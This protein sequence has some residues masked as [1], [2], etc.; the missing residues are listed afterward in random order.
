MTGG[1]GFGKGGRGW[2]EDVP[3]R[4]AAKRRGRIWGAF[5]SRAPDPVRLPH[6]S[7]HPGDRDADAQRVAGAQQAA[8]ARGTNQTRTVRDGSGGC[9]GR[10][11]GVP[12]RPTGWIENA[13]ACSYEA[14]EAVLDFEM[15]DDKRRPY[16]DIASR[17]A[18]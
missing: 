18:V 11:C 8:D 17:Q 9:R 7:S 2:A 1:G 5:L 13:D 15:G 6:A 12:A 3:A 14:T 10:P 16:T 4:S